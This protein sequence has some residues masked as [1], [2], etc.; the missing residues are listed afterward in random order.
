MVCANLKLVGALSNT[1]EYSR[2]ETI[3][4]LGHIGINI[5]VAIDSTNN[6]VDVLNRT[7]FAFLLCIN[8]DFFAIGIECNGHVIFSCLI[9]SE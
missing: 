5:P 2:E 8:T 7:G 6:A 4:T 9:N 1:R 3:G